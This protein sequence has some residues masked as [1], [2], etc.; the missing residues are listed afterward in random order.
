MNSVFPPGSC[1]TDGAGEDVLEPAGSMSSGRGNGQVHERGRERGSKSGS[2]STGC[3]CGGGTSAMSGSNQSLLSHRRS[4]KE[5]DGKKTHTGKNIKT[6]R[7][8]SRSQ[9]RAREDKRG[10]EFKSRRI[11]SFKVFTEVHTILHRLV[12]ALKSAAL[13][14]LTSSTVSGAA[15]TAHSQAPSSGFHN[16]TTHSSALWLEIT[17][18]YTLFE[19]RYASHVHFISSSSRICRRTWIID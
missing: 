8:R 13:S 6:L 2:I 9:Y 16:L 12:A 4:L 3:V 14:V 1:C 5:T 18:S 7:S 19:I 17:P 10:L 15:F 11:V